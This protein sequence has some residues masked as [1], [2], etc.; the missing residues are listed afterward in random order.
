MFVKRYFFAVVKVKSDKRVFQTATKRLHDLET[1][2]QSSILVSCN[3]WLQWDLMMEL[4]LVEKYSCSKLTYKPYSVCCKWDPML[5]EYVN[6][7]G[8]AIENKGA[9]KLQMSDLKF[10]L[11]QSVSAA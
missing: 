11:V 1:P 4:R 9:H 2:L 6:P 8:F 10:P 3:F 7:E 5:A